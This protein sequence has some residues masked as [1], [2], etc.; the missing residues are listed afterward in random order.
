ME[1]QEEL[2]QPRSFGN[3]IRHTSILSFSTRPREGVLTLGRP[4]NQVVTKERSIARGRPA[5][6]KAASPISISVNHQ[7]SRCGWS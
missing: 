3:S 2:A 5:R 4:E 7:I 6:T 1:F